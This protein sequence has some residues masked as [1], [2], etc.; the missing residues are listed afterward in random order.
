MTWTAHDAQFFSL[1]W[2]FRVWLFFWTWRLYIGLG[3]WFLSIDEFFIIGWSFNL[4]IRGTIWISH[5]NDWFF[6][7]VCWFSTTFGIW[8]FI[9]NWF[10]ASLVDTFF[11]KNWFP[12][13]DGLPFINFL[14]FDIMVIWV[15]EWGVQNWK[16]FSQKINI[17]RGNDWIL[18]IGVMVKNWALF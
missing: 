18:R 1:G 11:S 6:T 17:P 12:I 7:D 4:R 5:H 2:P 15:V 9:F 13:F 10:F 8:F 3:A 14:T 16:D